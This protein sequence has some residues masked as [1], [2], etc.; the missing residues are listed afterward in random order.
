MSLIS[1]NQHLGSL[2]DG[3]I[4]TP[5]IWT[6]Y[7]DIALQTNQEEKVKFILHYIF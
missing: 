4:W 6:L 3:I 1:I 7:I 2:L 5:E